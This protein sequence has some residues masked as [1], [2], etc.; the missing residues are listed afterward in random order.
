MVTP[1]SHSCT[2]VHIQNTLYSEL[3]EKDLP[4]RRR[5]ESGTAGGAVLKRRARSDA[6]A[7]EGQGRS[8]GSRS[9]AAAG[10]ARG[11]QRLSGTRHGSED[12][13]ADASR[14]TCSERVLSGSQ[15]ETRAREETGEH[16]ADEHE[17]TVPCLPLHCSA[18]KRP[19]PLPGPGPG[20]LPCGQRQS[21]LVTSQHQTSCHLVAKPLWQLLNLRNGLRTESR[22]CGW[23]LPVEEV[24]LGRLGTRV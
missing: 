4:F 20:R 19:P 13:Q 2:N 3:P 6:H 8:P 10:R 16:D 9:T 18:R 14:A 5:G 12:P 17:V 23:A 22:G 24:W 1:T 21:P 7:Q 11:W 15:C